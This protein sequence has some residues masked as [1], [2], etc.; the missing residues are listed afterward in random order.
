MLLGFSYGSSNGCLCAVKGYRGA[1]RRISNIIPCSCT[2]SAGFLGGVCCAQ[3]GLAMNNAVISAATVRTRINDIEVLLFSVFL[4]F[5]S[6]S[7]SSAQNDTGGPFF[8]AEL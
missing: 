1:I 5:A 2:K 4:N 6:K 3:I 8:P 7:R